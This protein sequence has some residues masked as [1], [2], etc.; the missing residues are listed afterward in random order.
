VKARTV[1]GDKQLNFTAITCTRDLQ[2]GPLKDVRAGKSTGTAIA[3]AKPFLE[4]R[5][6]S[7]PSSLL[8]C[9]VEHGWRLSQIALHIGRN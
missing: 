4:G 9:E 5:F 6:P 7:S 2:Q 3:A 8:G 1:A